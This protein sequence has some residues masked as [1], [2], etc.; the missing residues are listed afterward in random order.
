M[1]TDTCSSCHPYNRQ[2]YK[3]AET[4]SLRIA[5]IESEM[6]KRRLGHASPQPPDHASDAPQSGDEALPSS[7]NPSGKPTIQRQPA[8]VG[9][10]HEIDLGDD[11]SLRNR[12]R[13]ELAMRRA[14]GEPVPA[15]EPTVVKKPRLGRNGKPRRGPKRRN[16]EDLKRDQLVEQVL[17]ESRREWFV[18]RGDA[19]HTDMDLVDIYDEPEADG[20]EDSLDADERVAEQFKQDFMDAM[21]ARQRHR[22]AGQPK[23]PSKPG[24][25]PQ[26]GPK[27]GGSRSARAAMREQQEKALKK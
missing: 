19:H 23:A 27:L 25:Q 16:S 10:I 4:N 14:R 9:K 12:Q 24:E 5:Y 20:Q 18:K 3:A 15:E 1:S 2:L 22:T 17:H 11:A 8:S 13:T 26:R 7:D 21:Q 6:A